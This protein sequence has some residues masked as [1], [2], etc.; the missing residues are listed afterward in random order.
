MIGHAR[1]HHWLARDAPFA[2][3]ERLKEKVEWSEWDE[4]ASKAL[5][6]S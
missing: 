5:V 2:C 3:K 4:A 6:F 1:F